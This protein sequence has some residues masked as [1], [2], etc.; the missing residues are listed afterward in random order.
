[1][2]ELESESCDTE[3]DSCIYGCD[4]CPTYEPAGCPCRLKVAVVD[5]AGDRKS[6]HLDAVAYC[7]LTDKDGRFAALAENLKTDRWANI[8]LI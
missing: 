8:L 1:M 3:A 5:D 6:E 4:C 7:C 2:R